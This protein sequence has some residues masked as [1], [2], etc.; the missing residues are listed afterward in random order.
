MQALM[1]RVIVL[2]VLASACASRTHYPQQRADDLVMPSQP[3][4]LSTSYFSYT[5]SPVAVDNHDLAG[6]GLYNLRQLTYPS[7]GCNG[8]PGN[9]VTVHYHQSIVPGRWPTLI[10][11]PIWGVHTYPPRKITKL[12]KNRSHGKM[13]VLDV[14]GDVHLLDWNRLYAAPDEE[15]F[16]AGWK[17]SLERERTMVIDVRRLIDWAETRPE[18]DSKRI[19]LIGFSH[20]A[21]LTAVVAVQE[22][23]I[24]ATVLLFGGA[25]PHD[26]LAHC[27]GRRTMDL[28]SKVARDFGWS[29]DE[30]AQ[31]LEPILRVMDPARYPGRIDPATVLL[32][33]AERDPCIS[34]SARA[35]LREAMGHPERYT[36]D[37]THRKAFYT[38]TPLYFNWLRHRVWD[39][40]ERTL[41]PHPPAQ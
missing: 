16:H 28:Q 27:D 5:P 25:H 32:F 39:F 4:S 15:S 13:H 23:R 36:V 12:V 22:P 1:A 41:T 10:V 38:M 8:Q 17:E 30:L 37:A 9:L 26:V 29:K 35:A 21:M 14:Q 11:L 18:I 40:F 31:W 19:G 6:R 2:V 24:A 33:E 3:R 34:E 20:S 7:I